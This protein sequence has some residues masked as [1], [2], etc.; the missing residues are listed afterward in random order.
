MYSPD[1][2]LLLRAYANDLL[3]VVDCAVYRIEFP[4]NDYL[5]LSG[6]S[7]CCLNILYKR[8]MGSV[9]FATLQ[10]LRLLQ[11]AAGNQV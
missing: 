10:V 5:R 8:E 6:F 1:A 3:F 9:C 4:N 7:P 2:R 11:T